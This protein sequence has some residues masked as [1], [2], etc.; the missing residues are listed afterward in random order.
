MSTQGKARFG[1]ARTVGCTC[2]YLFTCRACCEAAKPWHWTPSDPSAPA[3]T[4]SPEVSK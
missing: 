2:D 1:K 3:P 4:P